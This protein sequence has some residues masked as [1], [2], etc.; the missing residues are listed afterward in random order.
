MKNNAA[1]ARNIN[2]P[3]LT[4]YGLGTIL[5]AG[6]YVLIGKVA[7]Q[8]GLLAPLAF[9]V[10]AVIAWV[11]ALSY[12]QLVILLPLSAG[13][14][15]YVD[16]A[17]H[18]KQ[19]TLLVGL[20]IILTG[21]VSAATLANGFIG[22]LTLFLNIDRAVGILLVVIILAIIACWGI[23][24][25]LIVSGLITVVEIL[26]IILVIALNTDT[27][28]SL[29]SNADNIHIADFFLPHSFASLTGI[30]SGAF[31]AFYAFI[32]FEDMVNVV[33]EVKEPESTMPKAI[34]LAIILSSLLYVIIALIAV[35]AIPVDTLASSDAPLTLLIQDKSA[36]GTVLLGLIGL[37]AIINGV[38]IQMIMAS[39]VI[40]GISQ[41][42]SRLSRLAQVNS[43]TQTPVIATVL[44]SALIIIFAL[45]L[46]IATL[47]KLTSFI[48]LIIFTLVHLA[49]FSIK[50]KTII[51]ES[52]K[53]KNY[54][55]LGAVLCLF[56]LLF[57]T[58]LFFSAA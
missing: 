38:L 42:S 20:L 30:F 39:R 26:G 9:I 22:Y 43:K 3:L 11:T 19:L 40:Y 1:L 41:K 34:I 56:L 31:L 18:R 54:P 46:P 12:S 44:V 33:E 35:V 57:Q 48:I 15:Y 45:F 24:E 50:R 25:S 8:A 32:G 6:I 4:L 52:I 23:S 27:L 17:F 28:I 37:F 51:P 16:Q 13:E 36:S 21:I 55:V 14:A 5:G 47:A 53:T 7:G 29:G 10:A 49:L 2:L 58:A